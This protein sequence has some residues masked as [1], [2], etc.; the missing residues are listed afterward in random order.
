[1]KRAYVL[2]ALLSIIGF[3]SIIFL[4]YSICFLGHRDLIRSSIYASIGILLLYI[5]KSLPRVLGEKRM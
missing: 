2:L 4:A 3:F 5:R 1:M